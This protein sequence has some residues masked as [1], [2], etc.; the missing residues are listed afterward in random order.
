[1]EGSCKKIGRASFLASH[2]PSKSL[3][4]EARREPRPPDLSWIQFL[5]SSPG[6]RGEGTRHV[7]PQTS[8]SAR[9]IVWHACSRPTQAIQVG[10]EILQLFFA[11]P[12][13]VISG[14]ERASFVNH[15][16]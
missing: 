8:L 6:Q 16:L 3:P 1:M 15:L 7:I 2:G 9:R 4:H 14:H 13:L 5:H 10:Q 11:Q 12:L